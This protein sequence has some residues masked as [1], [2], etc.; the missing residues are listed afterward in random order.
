MTQPDPAAS[1][2]S[3]KRILVVE[4][5]AIVAMLLETILEDI[6]CMP[7]G[8][9]LTMQEA[10]DIA[11]GEGSID[12]AILDVNL[13][14]ERVYPVAQILIDRGVPVIFA[15]GYGELDGPWKGRP[16][17]QKPYTM[18]DI[19]RVLTAVISG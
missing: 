12:A 2:L 17:V 18:D 8:P 16:A 19:V 10:R 6:G 4:D 13:H 15:T 7:V 14:G 11:G 3:S 9:A 1:L 5:E